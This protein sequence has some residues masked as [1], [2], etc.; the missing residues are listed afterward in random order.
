MLWDNWG[1]ERGCGEGHWHAHTRGLPWGLPEVVGTVP[2]VH[3]SWRRLL[4]RGLEFHVYTINKRS[5]T[6]KVWKLIVCTSYIYTQIFL[7]ELVIFSYSKVRKVLT[8]NTKIIYNKKWLQFLEAICIKNEK[9]LNINKIA[10]NS[11]TNI[12]NIFNNSK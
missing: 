10:F 2:E 6:K 8:D 11:G 3:C 4:R 5:N 9:K 1:D 12:S 7:I